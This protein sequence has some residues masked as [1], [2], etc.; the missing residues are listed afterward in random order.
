[1]PEPEEKEI[2][3][4]LKWK[5]SDY[6]EMT[7]KVEAQEWNTVVKV[8]ENGQIASIW[9]KVS[10][11]CKIDFQSHIGTIGEEMKKPS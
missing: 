3:I 11:I 5:N 1:M 6:F 7:Q 4:K 10:D 2:E 9:D 8:E